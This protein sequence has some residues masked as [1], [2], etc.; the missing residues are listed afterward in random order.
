[1]AIPSA[2]II[3]DAGIEMIYK[4]W[5]E[6]DLFYNVEQKKSV[7]HITKEESEKRLSMGSFK[8]KYF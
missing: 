5:E 2:R 7:H 3:I 1:M 8:G 6:G 4:N